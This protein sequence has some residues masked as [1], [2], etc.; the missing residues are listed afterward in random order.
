MKKRRIAVYGFWILAT[1]A[2]GALS[3]W[4][5]REDMRYFQDRVIQPPLSPPAIL[6]PIVWGILYLLMGVGMAR[7]VL[8]V[9][10]KERTNG[11]QIYL[12]QLAVNFIWSIVFFHLRSYLLALAV[13]MLLLGLILWMIHRF[14]QVDKPA[15]RL[16][17]PYL[18]WV[19]FAAYLNAGIYLLNR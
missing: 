17:I 12:L 8:S 7:V 9:Q 18:L 2:V 1:E 13:L 4:L 10:S 15:A 11:M 6:F 19:C 5:T 3:A 16:Q 14:R